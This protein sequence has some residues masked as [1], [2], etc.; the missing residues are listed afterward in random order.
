VDEYIL[1]AILGH[2]EPITFCGIKPLDCAGSH[3][4]VLP[5]LRTVQDHAM[6]KTTGPLDI[7]RHP[8]T[9]AQRGKPKYDCTRYL[10][11]NRL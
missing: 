2:D 8:K 5:R 6:L 4:C 1:A 11:Q 10:A 3:N 7:L 9:E